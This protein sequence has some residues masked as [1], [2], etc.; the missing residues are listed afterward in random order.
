MRVLKRE[1]G[2]VDEGELA[3]P[4]SDHKF[5]KVGKL[6]FGL[7]IDCVYDWLDLYARDVSDKPAMESF[8]A[9]LFEALNG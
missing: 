2:A 7:I 6:H 1:F 4:Y 8:V 9:R 3:G 5:L